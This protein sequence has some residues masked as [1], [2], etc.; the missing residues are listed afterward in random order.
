MLRKLKKGIEKSGCLHRTFVNLQNYYYNLFNTS[1]EQISNYTSSNRYPELFNFAKDFFHGEGRSKIK[2]LS[3]G[4]STGE[5]CFALAGYFPGSQITGVDINK[6]NLT[7]ARKR[8]TN[9]DISFLL[10]SQDIIKNNGPY[11]LILVM[12]VLCRWPA[13]NFK[14]NISKLYPFKRFDARLMFLNGVLN[15]GGLLLITN[16]N[17]RFSDSSHFSEYIEH[18]TPADTEADL[19]PKFSKEGKKLDIKPCSSFIFEKL[20]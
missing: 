12:S 9:P 6:S 11:D 10:S 17:Y 14:K 8:N 1:Y 19:V 2:I 18:K 5:E 20:K 7:L 15:P 4:C 13:S 16:A 3:F